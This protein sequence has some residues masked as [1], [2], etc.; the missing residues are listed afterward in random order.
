MSP[1]VLTARG[2]RAR[3]RRLNKFAAGEGVEQRLNGI[4][5]ACG[6]TS[7][8]HMVSLCSVPRCGCVIQPHSEY[9][10][11]HATLLAHFRFW[12][13]GA[14]GGVARFDDDRLALDQSR[15]DA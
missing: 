2:V 8:W 3:R 15:T 6:C 10:P 5:A 7:V 11:F 14:R 13:V 12:L 1:P 4:V 9:C